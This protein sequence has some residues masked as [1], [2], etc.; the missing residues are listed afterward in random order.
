MAVKVIMP[1]QGL[2]MTEGTITG[3]LVEEGGSCTE[4]TPL[5]EM[6]TD[7]LT[8]TM[9]A[10]ATGTLLKIIHGVDAV[11]PIT[12]TIAI[13]GEPGEDIAAL[14]AEAEAQNPAAASTASAA[15]AAPAA[16]PAAPAAQAAPAKEQEGKKFATPRAKM[17]AEEKSVNVMDVPASGP[18]NLVI[19]RDVLAYEPAPAVKATPLAKKIAEI[20]NVDLSEVK[21]TGSHGKIVKNDILS[22]V[23]ARIAAAQTVKAKEDGAPAGRTKRVVPMTKMRKIIAERMVASL[24]TEAQLQHVV[25]CDMTNAAALRE[26][27]KKKNKK[28]SYNDI[29]L[30]ATSRALMDFPMMNASIT[31][32]GIEMHDYVNLGMA[33]A[34]D[35]GLVVPNIKD[36]DMMRIDEIGV[37]AKELA[38]KAKNN[39][40]GLAEMSGG[41]FTVSNLGM[42]GLDQFTAIINPP[43]SGI[44][45]VGAITK[46]PVVVNDQI[47]IRPMM[48]VTLSYDHRIVDGAP[49]AEFLRRVKEYIEEPTLML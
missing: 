22:A 25:R 40:L 10:P 32:E 27:Y 26:V 11:V 7:K 43:E 4:G 13:I 5:F 49:A 14:L 47:V 15:P 38:D 24:Q 18:D 16:A 34:I 35:T 41:T 28:I 39:T 36:A 23:A 37:V 12:H 31:D 17:R 1:K 44:L 29:V 19:E 2:Q 42:F 48:S 21:G 46:T 33:V 8:I 45:A 3:W 9:D 20:E 30:Y 6:E